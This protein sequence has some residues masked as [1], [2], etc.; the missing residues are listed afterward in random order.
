MPKFKT[1]HPDARILIVDDE[2]IA[3]RAVSTALH[4][5]GYERVKTLEDSRLVIEELW[6]EDY[7]CVLLDLNMPHI[8]GGD[9]LPAI[10]KEFPYTFTVVMTG[11]TD[12]DTVVSCM[13]NGAFDYLAKPVDK[14]RLIA[15]IEKAVRMRGVE[16]EN[17]GLKRGLPGKDL[18]RPEAFGE[19]ITNHPRMKAIFSYIEAIA[20]S[21]Y[22]VLILGESGTGKE[23]IARSL[24]R[25]SERKGEFVA[26]NVSGLDDHLFSDTLFGHSKGAYTGADKERSGLVRKAEDGVLFLDEIGDLQSQSQIK[27]LRLLQEGEFQ[28][29]GT[30]KTSRTNAKFIFS[31]NKDLEKAIKEEKFRRDLYFRLRTHTIYLPPLRERMSDLP[32]L[33]R[34]FME[35]H[36]RLSGKP[37]PEF[38]ARLAEA[39]AHYDFPG[40]IRELECLITDAVV[41]SGQGLQPMEPFLKSIKYRGPEPKGMDGFIQGL[42]SGPEAM[43]TLKDMEAS[44]IFRVVQQSGNN[45]GEAARIL[46]M[47]YTSLYRRLKKMEKK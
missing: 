14:P 28:P 7:S 15:S 47:D 32:L 19:I 37:A 5:A 34:H 41:A 23:L 21:S 4:S 6:K 36:A 40:N 24:Y 43:P 8:S 22:P 2:P 20:G 11:L 31:T 39:L 30:D 18:K 42:V 26:V 38:P 33:I 45:L 1:S 9:L 29:L 35:K 46:G 44:Y 27:L 25:L 17:A 16:M 12:L 3:L 13:K 10:A